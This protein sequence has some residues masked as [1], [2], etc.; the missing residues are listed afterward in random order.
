MSEYDLARYEAEQE[1]EANAFWDALDF[2]VTAASMPTHEGPVRTGYTVTLDRYHRDWVRYSTITVRHYV[3]TTDEWVCWYN[4]DALAA[5]AQ[6][7][8]FLE[9]S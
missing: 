9:E 5:A 8:V 7:E 3:P 6:P 1:R 4:T 2:M